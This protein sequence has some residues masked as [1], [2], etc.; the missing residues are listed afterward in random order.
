MKINLNYLQ[1]FARILHCAIFFLIFLI[2]NSLFADGSK[3][4]FPSGVSGYRAFLRSSTAATENWPFPNEGVHYVYAKAGER[5][6]LASSA[7]GVG[8]GRIRL[9]SPT[10]TAVVNNT[11]TGNIA[12][13]TAE[14]AGPQL[15]GVTGGSKYTPIYYVVPSGGDGIYRVEFVSPGTNTS[16]TTVS[17]NSN[18]TQATNSNEIAAWDVSVINTANTGFVA[19]RVYTN[20]INFNMGTTSPNS[21]GF[22]GILYALTKDGY[23]YRVNNNGNNGMYFTFFVNNNGFIDTNGA[24]IYKSLASSVP[25]NLTGKVHNPNSADTSRQITHKMFYTLPNTD[26]PTTS[27]GAVPG[28]TTWLKS[29]VIVPVVTNVT[30]EGVEGTPQQIGVLKGGYI[31]FNAD[32]QGNYQILIQGSGFVTRTLSGSSVAGAN[33]IYWDGKDGAGVTATP[34]AV[35]LGMDVTV[36][37]QGGEVH[38][39][40]MDMEYNRNG[41]LL[42]LLNTNNLS[43]VVSDIVYWND[44]D[45]PNASNGSNPTP[46]NNSHLPPT[47]SN[48][49]SSA[50]NGHKWG[51]GGSGTNGTFGDVR[52]IDT[53]TFIKGEETTV[54]TSAILKSADLLVSSIT[55]NKT[56]AEVGDQVAYTVKF[57]NNGPSDVPG[58]KVTVKIPPGFTPQNIQF[59]GGTCGSESVPMTFDSAT[60]TYSSNVNLPNGC[61]VTYVITVVVNNL[62]TSGNKL[63]EAA[64]LRVKD[65]TDPDATNPNITVM[66]TDAY[67]ECANNGLGI[68]CNNI[69]GNT[70]LVIELPCYN[71]ASTATGIASNHGITLQK[72]A[73]SGATNW[74]GI[75]KS[76]YTVLE[77]GSKGFVITRMTSDPSQ[78]SAA[79]YLS[80]DASSKITNPQEGM[81]VYDTYAKCLKIFDGTSWKCF[82]KPAC[83]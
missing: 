69:K 64:I 72:R 67:S 57:K 43:Q 81:M 44:T 82:S 56:L 58:A 14:L 2:S 76:A 51:V 33:Q 17:A 53:W 39:P 71:T 78:V 16:S 28:G 6:T 26:M 80:D 18:W 59:T 3:D 42:E 4:L 8:S 68:A 54:M 25:A 7:Q 63:Y 47:N 27:A 11:S 31:K 1:N 9:Y 20:V 19:G 75:R 45:V 55:P 60:N 15:S 40:F 66:P 30:I 61:E 48:G 32:V 41:F 36:R 37:L 34:G 23:I 10:N 12:N 62:V 74:P 77:S 73:N 22:Y 21:N 49:I 24:P 46:K 38:F 79:N 35:A 65:N 29:T 5:I 13:R 83:P 52:A 70:E 50:T